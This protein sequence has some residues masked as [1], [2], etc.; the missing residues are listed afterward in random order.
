MT[1]TRSSTDARINADTHSFKAIEQFKTQNKNAQQILQAACI[2]LQMNLIGAEL[3]KDDIV[4]VIHRGLPPAQVLFDDNCL[5]QPSYSVIMLKKVVQFDSFFPMQG[6]VLSAIDDASLQMIPNVIGLVCL[7]P[8]VTGKVGSVREL[9]QSVVD[10][11][12]KLQNNGNL[13]QNESEFTPINNP[14]MWFPR[15]K[16][17][18]VDEVVDDLQQ[19]VQNQD[20]HRD[21]P[22]HRNI[23]NRYRI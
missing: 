23:F 18:Q 20:Y 10:R 4:V 2:T 3:E 5:R 16:N 7:T 15:Q 11:Y 22:P 9:A 13:D 14:N 1:N 19:A 21:A 12:K 17:R 8:V 6:E